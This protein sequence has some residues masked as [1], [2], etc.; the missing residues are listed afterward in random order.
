[1]QIYI[2][3]LIR[4]MN[5]LLRQKY[6]SYSDCRFYFCQVKDKQMNVVFDVLLLNDNKMQM[7]VIHL[8]NCCLYRSCLYT[9]NH[10]VLMNI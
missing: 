4:K 8:S 7:N 6:L 9:S 1:M 5:Y 10:S 2:R 3:K